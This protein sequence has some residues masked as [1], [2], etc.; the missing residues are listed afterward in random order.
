MVPFAVLAFRVIFPITCAPHGHAG[1]PPPLE[2]DPLRG[3]EILLGIDQFNR[4]IHIGKCLDH[5]L[6]FTFPHQGAVDKDR[7]KL[8]SEC[9]VA[10]HRHQRTI[11]APAQSVDRGGFAY[12]LLDLGD[13]FFDK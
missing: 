2:P 12:C 8:I 11:H 13:L 5:T 4:D 1:C 7:F 9:A 6:R 3:K 10:K